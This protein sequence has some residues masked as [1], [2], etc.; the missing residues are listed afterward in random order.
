MKKLALIPTFLTLGLAVGFFGTI[1]FAQTVPTAGSF[2]IGEHISYNVSLDKFKNVA[3][4]ETNVASRGKIAGQDVVEIV[5]RIKTE[6]FVSAAIVLIDETRTVY[7]AIDDGRPLLIKRVLDG[8]VSAHQIDIDNTKA[9]TAPFD[10]FAA[11]FKAR[12][13][14]GSGSFPFAEDG[15]GS[16]ITFLPEGSQKVTTDQGTFETTSVRVSSPYFDSR[17]FKNVRLWLS[18]TDEKIPVAFE[19]KSRNGTFRGTLA[20]YAIEEQTGMPV[21]PTP[22][23]RPSV[24]PTPQKP[25]VRPTPSPTP[26]IPNQPLLSELKFRL[27]ERLNYQVT[28][29]GRSVGSFSLA[30]PERKLVG[31]QDTLVLEAKVTGVDGAN[32]PF[33]LGDGMIANVSPESLGPNTFNAHLSKQ[34]AQYSQNAAFDQRTGVVTFGPN[35]EEGPVGVHSILSLIYAMRSFNL[36]PSREASNPVN[37]TRVAVFWRDKVHIFSLRPSRPEMLTLGEKKV[38]AQLITIVTGD[39][40]VDQLGFK[41]WLSMGAA[42]TPLRFSIGGFQG[43]LISESNSLP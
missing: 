12:E 19:F 41:I 4:V 9:S 39:P 15:E 23:P 34:L 25:I 13:A 36:V 20:S 16:T 30:V 24:A 3:F 32:S 7:A 40:A 27:G 10:L 17:G 29:T 28:N 6:G 37:D 1:T 11:L 43:D 18:N 42:R 14:N 38:E 33:S 35:K 31:V 26:Y 22:T 21:D 8:G 5:G 2:R